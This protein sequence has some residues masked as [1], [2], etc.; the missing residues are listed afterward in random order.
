MILTGHVSEIPEDVWAQIEGTVDAGVKPI[1]PVSDT[2]IIVEVD[3][4]RKV[5]AYSVGQAMQSYY[6]AFGLWLLSGQP[7]EGMVEEGLAQLGLAVAPL[8]V[9]EEHPHYEA[10][11]F[12]RDFR[13]YVSCTDVPADWPE[14]LVTMDKVPALDWKKHELMLG[15]ILEGIQPTPTGRGHEKVMAALFEQIAA[16]P[17]L[18]VAKL[19]DGKIVGL[20]TLLASDWHGE[21]PDPRLDGTVYYT[22]T[23]L[24]LVEEDRALA[25][26]LLHGAALLAEA[27]NAHLAI[28]AGTDEAEKLVRDRLNFQ[29]IYSAYKYI[30]ES[31]FAK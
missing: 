9:V 21:K 1:L 19:V 16:A 14:G 31:A 8:T 13:L 12:V 24:A 30:R 15:M 26:E 4:D 18:T 28:H 29:Y 25:G 3:D 23:M 10:V 7:S 2:K 27:Q 22:D 20:V 6:I 11:G 17:E 5:V